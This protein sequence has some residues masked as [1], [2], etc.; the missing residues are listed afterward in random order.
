MP[1]G[2]HLRDVREQL[3]DAAERV[4]LRDGPSELT[5]RA[6]TT[7][8]GCAK[9]VLHR[10]F[11]DF[12]GFLAELVEDRIARLGHT[13]LRESAGTGTVAD[14]LTEA[15]TSLFTSVAVAMVSLITFRDELRARLRRTH[16]T[17]VPLL[18]E[19]TA[20]VAD[21]LTAERDRGRLKE[22]ADVHTLAP[23]LI[24][25]AHLLFADR[26]GTPP[27]PEAVHRMVTTTLAGVL[28]RD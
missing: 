14:N 25:A 23:T 18:T 9:G 12:D 1:T 15:L 7:E 8:A 20:M 6:V 17:G 13:A 16:P 11:P 19:A 24:G 4:L 28:A 2:V 22:N 27:E 3:F 10:H 21:Y 5:S 26:K